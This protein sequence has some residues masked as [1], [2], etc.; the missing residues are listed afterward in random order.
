MKKYYL[1]P[2]FSQRIQGMQQMIAAAGI[3]ISFETLE[4]LKMLRQMEEASAGE[5]MQMEGVSFY[6]RFIPGPIGDMKVRI[7]KPD[8]PA[9][10]RPAFLLYHGGGTVI[11]GLNTEH[12]RALHLSK[13]CGAVGIS[14]DYH[15]APEYPAPAGQEDCYAALKWVNDHADE[16]NI[17][18]K[19]IGITGGSGGGMLTLSV[20]QMA[21]DRKEVTPFIQ[22]PLYPNTDDREQDK[23]QSRIHGEDT[24]IIN[25]GNIT[26]VMK[27]ILGDKLNNPPKYVIPNRMEDLSGLCRSC[28]VLSQ[29]DPMIDEQMDYI[30]KLLRAEVVTE[31]HL[32]PG[33]THAFDGVGWDT[34]ITTDIL[35]IICKAFTRAIKESESV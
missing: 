12:A 35:D 19:Y 25:R 29:N 18:S 9:S 23:F 17:N 16:L 13:G 1:T 15:L 5:P 33:I 14:V 20:A 4:D 30:Q 27:H 7:Y 8:Q 11:G 34:E 6:D 28:F 3:K 2:E 22:I 26:H 32:M 31:V 21:R 24:Y 10:E